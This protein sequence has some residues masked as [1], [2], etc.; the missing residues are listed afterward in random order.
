MRRQQ[1]LSSSESSTN[2]RTSTAALRT[3]RSLAP[4]ASPR[5]RS[6]RGGHSGFRQLPDRDTLIALARLTGVDYAGEVI[7][8]ALH[9]IG[10]VSRDA[11]PETTSE[12]HRTA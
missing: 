5:R 11:E 8:A 6:Q 10:Y 12:Q 2:T 1:D 9:D 4:S 7:P 3:P